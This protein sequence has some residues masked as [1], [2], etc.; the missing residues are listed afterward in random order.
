MVAFGFGLIHGFGFANALSDLGLGQV[1]LLL[2]LCGFNLGVEVG[3]LA[4]VALF[5]PLAFGLRRSWFYQG[6]LLRLGSAF[7]ILVAGMWLMERAFN[8][9]LLRL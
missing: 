7:I 5:L 6:F 1:S 4:I 2:T 3:Q 8:F 9:G